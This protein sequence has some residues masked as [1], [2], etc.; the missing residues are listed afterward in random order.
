MRRNAQK[1]FTFS[2][3]I[4]QFVASLKAM[5]VVNVECIEWENLIDK[6]L[7]ICMKKTSLEVAEVQKE[8]KIVLR[9]HK[10]CFLS[11]P[12]RIENEI[13][14]F[15]S[16]GDSQQYEMT[17]NLINT[18]KEKKIHRSAPE[19]FQFFIVAVF[20]PFRSIKSEIFPWTF[21]HRT[22]SFVL[23]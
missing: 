19:T 22:S 14:K 3:L 6:W 9:T 11:W 10:N 5:G 7:E 1:I 23:L 17:K 4:V 13:V 16:A 2:L 12:N 18:E 15:G 21:L 8:W 20:R